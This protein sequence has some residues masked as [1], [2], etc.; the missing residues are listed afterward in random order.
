[1]NQYLN[2]LTVLL[3]IKVF[4]KDELNRSIAFKLKYLTKSPQAKSLIQ[5]YIAPEMLEIAF[6]G[7]AAS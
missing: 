3:V 1:M 2:G 6:L 4:K 7:N 5:T